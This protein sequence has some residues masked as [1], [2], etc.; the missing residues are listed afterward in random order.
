M[1]TLTN[2]T[3]RRSGPTLVVTGTG[4]AGG[5]VKIAGIDVIK[6]ENGQV[7]AAEGPNRAI[8]AG[9]RADPIKLRLLVT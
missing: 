1:H 4:E 8:L 7:I 3:V 9:R 6:V 5:P 2:W